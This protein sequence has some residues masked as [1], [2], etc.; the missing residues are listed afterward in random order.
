MNTLPSGL[1]DR[2]SQHLF[3]HS[4]SAIALIS[5]DL[6][7]LALGNV[8]RKDDII[9]MLEALPA[10]GPRMVLR[11]EIEEGDGPTAVHLGMPFTSEWEARDAIAAHLHCDSTDSAVDQL[12]AGLFRLQ[13]NLTEAAFQAASVSK[14]AA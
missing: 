11:I 12:M 13:Q 7:R 9:A 3:L 6:Q 5:A 14:V 10:L 8:A 4:G 1:A 2:L